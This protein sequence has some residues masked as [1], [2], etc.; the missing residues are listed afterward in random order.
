MQIIL[1]YGLLY[2]LTIGAVIFIARHMYG[3]SF[4]L[5][6]VSTTICILALLCL[7][8][9]GFVGSYSE[10]MSANFFQHAVGGG[11]ACGL[12]CIVL[13]QAFSLHL[14]KFSLLVIIIAAVSTLGVMN[15][16]LE[17]V[18]QSTTPLMFSFDN[19]DT[20]RDLAANTA[21]ALLAWAVSLAIYYSQKD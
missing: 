5:K 9:A 3:A 16:L 4:S 20:W 7:L 2:A 21:G 10:S 18:L 6:R 19:A 17:F 1:V 11:L 8:A 15:E 14:S 13:L 12:V